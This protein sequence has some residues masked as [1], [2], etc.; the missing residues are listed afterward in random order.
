MERLKNRLAMHRAGKVLEVGTG[1]GIFIP[2]I[3]DIFNQIDQLIGI[4]MD[5][6]SILHAQ[7]T[8]KDN[9]RLEFIVMNA[10][11][12]SYTDHTFDTV[13]ISNALHH[14]PV[15]SKVLDEMKRVL[16]RNGLFFIN[17]L[18]CDN[19]NEAQITHVMYHHF[20]SEIDRRLGMYHRQTYTKQ[21]ILDQ[22]EQK[23]IRI[24]SIFEHNESKKNV[25]AEQDIYLVSI[26]CQK[27]IERTKDLKDH[28]EFV[29]RGEEI[30][31]RLHQVGIQRPTQL[32][33]LGSV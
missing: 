2:T 15:E 28:L 22:I 16:K 12:L 29:R 25:R 20:S 7:N 6:D 33:I 27:H 31:E 18:F 13:C 23:G 30:I 4:D 8:Y 19:Q 11:Q 10:E 24:E 3:L 1:T 32:M 5:T 17:E 14:T 21:E 26:A 9:T